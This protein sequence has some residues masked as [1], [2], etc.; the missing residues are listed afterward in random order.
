MCYDGVSSRLP[1]SGAE[2]DA[3]GS[4]GRKVAALIRQRAR[5]IR[6]RM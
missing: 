1:E 2:S 4:G 6:W 5:E 3:G